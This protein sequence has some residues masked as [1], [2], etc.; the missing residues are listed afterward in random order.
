VSSEGPPEACRW[1]QERNPMGGAV[2]L[3]GGTVGD[4][5]LAWRAEVGPR[6]PGAAMRSVWRQLCS[7]SAM[8]PLRLLG[9]WVQEEPL[10]WFG[11]T[12]CPNHVA[13]RRFL[14]ARIAPDLW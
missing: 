5:R 9:S 2:A 14:P 6:V 13:L 4:R 8:K 10:A 12:K 11:P 3:S 7:S 1:F